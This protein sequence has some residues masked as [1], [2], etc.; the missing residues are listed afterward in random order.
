MSQRVEMPPV[1]ENARIPTVAVAG[2]PRKAR[3]LAGVGD[4]VALGC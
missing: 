4:E 3:T 1:L 2:A